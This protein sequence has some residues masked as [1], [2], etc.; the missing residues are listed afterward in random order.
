MFSQ[1]LV[2]LW[3]FLI[4]FTVIDILTIIDGAHVRMHAHVRSILKVPVPGKS[5]LL[6]K[7]VSFGKLFLLL[8]GAS[9]DVGWRFHVNFGMKTSCDLMVLLGDV[10]Y[11]IDL[12]CSLLEFL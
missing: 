5:F 12:L 6:Y 7:R 2:Y 4:E 11:V 1:R 3:P 10:C 9:S 8:F